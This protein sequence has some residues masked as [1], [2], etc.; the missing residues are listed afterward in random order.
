MATRPT[1]NVNVKQ[2]PLRTLQANLAV[3]KLPIGYSH[4]FIQLHELHWLQKNKTTSKRI[5]FGAPISLTKNGISLSQRQAI[6]ECPYFFNQNNTPLKPTHHLSTNLTVVACLFSA[7]KSWLSTGLAAFWRPM[8][9]SRLAEHPHFSLLT[10]HPEKKW[11]C[12]MIP[13]MH[14]PKPMIY[15]MS[16]SSP[17]LGSAILPSSHS[18]STSPSFASERPALDSFGRCFTNCKGGTIVPTSSG[19][20]H[21]H[22]LVKHYQNPCLAEEFGFDTLQMGWKRL[23]A[24]GLRLDEIEWLNR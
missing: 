1:L 15:S 13:A 7:L 10:T 23:K 2:L 4:W 17:N 24:N 6:H 20:T 5:V 16:S 9:R 11:F 8:S 22:F 21:G 3:A 14:N 18:T 19:V 12:T